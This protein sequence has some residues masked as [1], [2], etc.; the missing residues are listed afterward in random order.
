MVGSTPVHVFSRWASKLRPRGTPI[1]VSTHVW[2][3]D[4]NNTDKKPS[5]FETMRDYSDH[6]WPFAFHLVVYDEGEEQ[7]LVAVCCS[8][9]AQYP[10]IC[11]GLLHNIGITE[12]MHKDV[13]IAISFTRWRI[14]FG[15]CT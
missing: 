7:I 14:P 15:L 2:K 12:A 3:T 5:F 6:S 10:T 9:F 1:S 13:S 11:H 8:V 4:L